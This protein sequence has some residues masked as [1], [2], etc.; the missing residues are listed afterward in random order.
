MRRLY[1]YLVFKIF[2]IFWWRRRC[3]FW[4]VAF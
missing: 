3:L 4:N 2:M 1:D